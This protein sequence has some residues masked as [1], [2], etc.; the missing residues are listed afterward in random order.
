M[1]WSSVKRRMKVLCDVMIRIVKPFA[2]STGN[3]AARR[4]RSWNYCKQDTDLRY[5][6]NA[7]LCFMD[8]YITVS[9]SDL[10]PQ[11]STVTPILNYSIIHIHFAT[12]VQLTFPRLESQLQQA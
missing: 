5:S 9:E 12:L 10:K 3:R 6:H 1:S 7:E 11:L 2:G 4:L 8:G